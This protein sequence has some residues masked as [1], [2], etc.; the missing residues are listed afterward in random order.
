MKYG[1]WIFMLS[2]FV[3][4]TALAGNL[5]SVPNTFFSG[6]AVFASEVNENF[7]ALRV[8]IDDNANSKQNNVTGTCAVG[9]SVQQINADGTVVCETYANKQNIVTGTCTVGQSIRQIN[10][11]GTVA[12]ETISISG[13]DI[14]GVTAGAGL[15]GGG[16]AGEVAL[17]I[18]PTYQIPPGMVSYFA[19]LDCPAGW[20]MADGAQVLV[21]EYPELAADL[22]LVTGV[23]FAA[24][25]LP[26]LRGQFIRGWDDGLGD[27]ILDPGRVLFSY[28]ADELKSHNHSIYT[29]GGSAGP[30]VEIARDSNTDFANKS[31]GATGGSETRPRNIAL[32]ACI[33]I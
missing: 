27:V 6:G 11:D 12:C 8:E 28:Q 14:T 15:T 18:D 4:S 3:S 9:S 32:L 13:G 33:K 17:S 20:F 7:E 5:A 25:E 10:T 29:A 19:R 24:V 16:T 2:L 21:S 30:R 1:N 23:N 31:T 26:D 22:P